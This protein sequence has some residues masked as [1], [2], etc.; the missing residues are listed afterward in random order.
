MRRQ[1]I[2]LLLLPSDESVCRFVIATKV[3]FLL[4]GVDTDLHRRQRQI[5]TCIVR[6]EG[7]RRGRLTIQFSEVNASSARRERR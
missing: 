6:R 2:P 3:V 1:L 4:D 5:R 7:E